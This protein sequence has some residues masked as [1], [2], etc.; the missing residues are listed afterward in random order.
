MKVISLRSFPIA[1]NS[2]AILPKIWK[3]PS[4]TGIFLKYPMHEGQA[5]I[6][7][8]V[9]RFSDVASLRAAFAFRL[10]FING[11]EGY[12]AFDVIEDTEDIGRKLM[13][14]YCQKYNA[15]RLGESTTMIILPEGSEKLINE[16]LIRQE[17]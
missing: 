2:L 17:S 15:V 14:M 8:S 11:K 16:Y 12:L 7:S 3:F 13:Q 5:L 1:S 10:S 6:I 9:K 4:I